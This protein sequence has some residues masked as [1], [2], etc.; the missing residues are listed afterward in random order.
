MKVP[1][2]LP[3]TSKRSP[4][5]GVGIGCGVIVVVLILV[6]VFLLVFMMRAGGKHVEVEKFVSDN[7]VA[8]IHLTDCR[9]DAGVKGLLGLVMNLQQ[10]L[11]LESLQGSDLPPVFQGMSEYWALF[12]SGRVDAGF[13]PEVVVSIM[14]DSTGTNITFS[15]AATL[16]G[17]PRIVRYLISFTIKQSAAGGAGTEYRKVSVMDM[18]DFRLAMP[19]GALFVAEEMSDVEKMIDRLRDGSETTNILATT[20]S[21]WNAKWDLYTM[22][23]NREGLLTDALSALVTEDFQS[24]VTTNSVVEAGTRAKMETDLPG[25]VTAGTIIQGELGINIVAE[26]EIQG[27]LLLDCTTGEAARQIH[28]VVRGNIDRAIEGLGEEA[29]EIYVESKTEGNQV[30]FQ[31]FV[32]QFDSWLKLKS[33]EMMTEIQNAPTPS[34]GVSP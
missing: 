14:P 2:P 4:W 29:I 22:F 13:I 27:E 9:E 1:P 6:V 23:E 18:G 26:S 33:K 24:K 16:T 19:R 28:D 7:A 12:Q 31:I 3:P 5:V 20:S 11:Y 30:Q 32:D 25:A 34:S 10:D 17:F 21:E 8:V 15:V